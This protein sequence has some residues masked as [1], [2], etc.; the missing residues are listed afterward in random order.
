MCNG[1]NLDKVYTD[2]HAVGDYLDMLHE[3]FAAARKVEAVQQRVKN[4]EGKVTNVAV[5]HVLH[6]SHS[7]LRKLAV[8]LRD[9]ENTWLKIREIEELHSLPFR[10]QQDGQGFRVDLA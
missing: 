6:R 9:V 2:D 7:D 5:K 4:I 1:C 8:G 10:A 3:L